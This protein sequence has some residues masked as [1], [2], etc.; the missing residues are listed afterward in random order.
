MPKQSITPH[1]FASAKGG[2][3]KSTLAVACAKL[4]ASEAGRRCVL[5]DADM[6]G[7]SLADGLKLC[8]PDVTAGRDGRPKSDAAPTG[9]HQL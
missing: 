1:A 9:R 3:G 8:A 4:I 6:T 2:V 7:T 5:V